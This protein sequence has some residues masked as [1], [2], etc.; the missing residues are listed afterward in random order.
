MDLAQAVALF[1]ELGFPVAVAAFVLIRMERRLHELTVA[2]LQLR[3]VLLTRLPL[4]S[5]R[6]E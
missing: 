6:D 3:A 4:P 5:G 1:R 2:I